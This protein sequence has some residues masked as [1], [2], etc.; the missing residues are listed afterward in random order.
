MTSGT[1]VNVKITSTNSVPTVCEPNPGPSGDGGHGVQLSVSAQHV[2]Q[3]G[4][5]Q[6][7]DLHCVESRRAI[8]Y[9]TWLGFTPST[10]TFSGSQQATDVATVAVH[11]TASDGTASVSDEFNNGVSCGGHHRADAEQRG[12][13]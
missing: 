7:A 3:R 12:F 5:R 13:G 11:V 9:T 6:H 1:A 10:R 2:P 4:H 8:R